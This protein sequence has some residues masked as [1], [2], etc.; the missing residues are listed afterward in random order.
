MKP[1]LFQGLMLVFQGASAIGIG[2]VV[3]FAFKAGGW[4]THVDEKL[5]QNDK[6]HKRIF[7]RIDPP[8]RRTGGNFVGG[9]H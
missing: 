6:E 7:A 1:E 9:G 8:P 4:K 3:I 5:E 2:A